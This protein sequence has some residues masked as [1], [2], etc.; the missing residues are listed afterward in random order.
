MRAALLVHTLKS[1]ALFLRLL[2]SLLIAIQISPAVFAQDDNAEAVL[3][4][5]DRLA[6]LKSWQRAEPLFAKA[7]QV[8]KERGDRRNELYARIGRLRG[9]LP[10]MANAEVSATLADLLTEPLV[11]SDARLRLRCLAVKGDTDLDMDVGLAGRDWTEA[12]ELAKG[13]G[14][15]PWVARATGELGIIAF[16][17]GDSTGALI[18]MGTALKEAQANNDIGAEIRYLALFGN[19]MTEFGRPDQG[20]VYF[21]RALAV[22]AQAGKDLGEPMLV[23]TGKTTALAALGRA[24]EAKELLE[25]ALD[26]AKQSNAVGYQGE[27]G[28]QLGLLA[29]KGGNTTEAARRFEEASRLC[30]EVD[31]WRTVT[32]AQFELSKIYEAQKNLPAAERAAKESVIACRRLT[33]RFYLPRYLARQAHLQVKLG[34]IKEAKATYAE[35]EDVIN[36]ILVNAS[37]PW[38]KSSLIAA[39]NDVFVGHLRSEIQ[40]GQSPGRVFH[41]VEEARGRPVADLLRAR[42]SVQAPQSAELTA[43]ERK[44]AGLQI[45]LQKRT[46]SRERQRILDQLYETEQSTAPLTAS[47]NRW[48]RVATQPVELDQ[49]QR[50]LAFDA[51]LLEYV[52]DDPNSYCIVIS[53]SSARIQK[54]ASRSEIER[55]VRPML[56]DLRDGKE[57]S[58]W[59]KRV[60]DLVLMPVE[61]DV[62]RAHRLVVVPDGVLHQLPLEVLNDQRGEAVLVSHVVSYAPA[63]SV[64]ALLT[65]PASPHSRRPLLAISAQPSGVGGSNSMDGAGKPFGATLRGVY[66]LDKPE[67][68]ALP[69]ANGEVRDVA[70]ILGKQSVVLLNATEADVKAQPL[71]EFAVLHFASPP[72]GRGSSR[73][74]L[75]PAKLRIPAPEH[76]LQ[77]LVENLCSHLQQEMGP[78]QRPLH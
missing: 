22:V 70:T 28:Y 56:K 3:A 78:A 67:M 45:A 19:G 62:A 71:S 72:Q 21:D 32:Q 23:Y 54:L 77:F 68:P 38:T 60:Y 16:L 73:G 57:I 29:S 66:D 17:K 18:K 65:R 26:M 50:S 25:H 34:R 53:R 20:L 39:M 35:A 41:V 31:G 46:V 1:S 4:E 9:Q 24:A 49:V 48:M 15:K 76:I 43:A 47:A 5:A 61:G 44:I 40:F 11:Q 64:I 6:W 36:G 52:L 58:G 10:T 75:F 13:L 30:E 7:E 33:D 69:E 55:R 51:L 8:F 14:D 12:L 42:P 27:I 2:A 74:P 59:S 63:G 37:S